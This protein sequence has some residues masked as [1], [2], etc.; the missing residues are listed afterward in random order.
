METRALAP[1]Y[2]PT[3]TTNGATTYGTLVSS[4]TVAATSSATASAQ[5]PGGAPT[6]FQQIQIANTSSAWAYVTFGVYGQVTASTVATGYP[7][8]PG[9]VVVV[10]VHP[11]VTG[12]SVIL[13]SGSGNVVLTR[14]E[15]L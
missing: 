5:L 10:S 3:T 2:Q 15:G 4:V 12:A 1:L 11:E 13:S 8:A 9:G 14:G 7:V 6:G